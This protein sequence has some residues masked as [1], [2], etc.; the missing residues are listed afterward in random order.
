MDG[1]LRKPGLFRQRFALVARYGRC[2]TVCMKTKV[3][4]LAQHDEALE[5]DVELDFLADLTV[6]QR[7]ELVL[8]RSK[9]LLDMLRENGHPLTPGV[10]KRS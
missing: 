10:T 4:K 2:Y 7:F 5:R 9:L 3:T 8:E 1:L 6:E